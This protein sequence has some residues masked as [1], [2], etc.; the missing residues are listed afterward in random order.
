MYS[1]IGDKLG[2]LT[3]I[4]EI[5]QKGKR[6]KLVCVCSCGETRTICNTKANRVVSCGCKNQKPA[7]KKKPIEEIIATTVYGQ[8]KD[9]AKNK[10]IDF[11]LTKDQCSKM[12]FSDC[13]YCGSP[14]ARLFKKWRE[15]ERGM[16]NGIDRKDNQLGYTEKNTV[17]CCTKCN[18]IKNNMHIDEFLSWV[19]SVYEHTK[20]IEGA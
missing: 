1:R 17:P 4:S 10:N 15:E 20:V 2:H 5:K 6:T 12:F 14:P 8:Y 19:R 11:N 16:Y 9:N 13:H 7:K 18:Y 3:V